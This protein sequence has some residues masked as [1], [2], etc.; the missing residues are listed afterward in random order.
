MCSCRHGGQ[1]RYVTRADVFGQGKSDRAAD[2]FGSEWFHGPN[3]DKIRKKQIR[4]AL[5]SSNKPTCP[6]A[7][8]KTGVGN[9]KPVFDQTQAARRHLGSLSS[10]G[11]PSQRPGGA[12][13]DLTAASYVIHFDRWRNPAIENHATDRAFRIGQKRKVVVHKFT[14]RGPL[15]GRIPELIVSKIASIRRRPKEDKARM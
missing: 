3:M 9:L 13:L 6:A 11:S 8:F 12:G 2:L 14:C 4:K 7:Y 15:K 1:R 10:N 5:T